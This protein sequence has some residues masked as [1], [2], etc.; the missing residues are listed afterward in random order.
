MC[1][2][3]PALALAAYTALL[4]LLVRSDLTPNLKIGGNL[5]GT[6]LVVTWMVTGVTGSN[7]LYSRLDYPLHGYWR[8]DY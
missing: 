6:H 2:I 8:L 5:C 7:H 3:V 1:L 4:Y